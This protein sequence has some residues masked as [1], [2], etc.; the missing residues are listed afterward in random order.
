MG[1]IKVRLSNESKKAIRAKLRL[2]EKLPKRVLGA[3]A[4]D[5]AKVMV[6]RISTEIRSRVRIR[7]KDLDE[8][9]IHTSRADGDRTWASVTVK[10]ADR[11]SLK[12]FDA[13]SVKGSHTTK[14]ALREKLRGGKKGRPVGAKTLARDVS[15]A[16]VALA[17]TIAGKKGRSE[18]RI[19]SSALRKARGAQRQN[20][21]R[22][23]IL[24]ELR[25]HSNI[26]RVGSRSYGGVRYNL[27]TKGRKFIPQAFIGKGRL[28]GH[29]YIRVNRW[30]DPPSE[31]GLMKMK[32]SRKVTKLLGTSP[33][34]VLVANRLVF[35]LRQMAKDEM[36]KAVFRRLR[37]E[38]VKIDRG[39]A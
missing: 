27:S 21:E 8:K 7:K 17:N 2:M 28:H 10:A 3:A 34:G 24:A 16:R 11:F 35:G 4:N 13:V 12:Y 20:R 26:R 1:L 15:S 37:Y 32:Y 38:L 22:Q 6:T 5:A 18:Y 39:A 31:Y 29:V 30:P 14:A 33:W 23:K 19:A 25:K 9:Y 36:A